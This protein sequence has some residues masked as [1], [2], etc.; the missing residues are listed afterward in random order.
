[1]GASPMAAP[2][3]GA[4]NTAAAVN[5]LKGMFPLMYKLLSAFS[6]GSEDWKNASDGIRSFGKIVGKEPDDSA[7][8]SAIRQM[9]LA[10]KG[11]PMRA[12]PPIAIQPNVKPPEEPE[13][14]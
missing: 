1:M 5:A 6:P 10:G 12:A 11:N 9:V 4:G 3:A 14:V 8:P 2:G 7:V 13:P